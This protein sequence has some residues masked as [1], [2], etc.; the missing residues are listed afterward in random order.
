MAGWAYFKCHTSVNAWTL[1]A[2]LL[3]FQI[4]ASK[5]KSQERQA[6]LKR[7]RAI[8][9]A[10]I[11]YI[12]KH[13]A[14]EGL[15]KNDLEN[16]TGYYQRQR[17]QIEK[18][19][20]TGRLYNLR[21]QLNKLVEFPMRMC[22]LTFSKYIMK[23][24]GYDIDIFESLQIRVDEII[25]QNQITPKKQL[26]D[27]IIALNVYKQQSVDQ[28]KID[29]LTNLLISYADKTNATKLSNL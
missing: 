8:L 23:T 15:P 17:Q 22:D 4:H 13:I 7:H 25:K 18:S 1:P 9:M 27:I 26:S 20:E 21:Q 29:I 3:R 14:S 10:T 16:I 11:D 24:T 28:S 5:L 12:L 6:D 19:F 2:T